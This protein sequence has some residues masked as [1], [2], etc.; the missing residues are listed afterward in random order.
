LLTDHLLL[1][2]QIVAA[3]AAK[4]LTPAVLELG[5]KCPCFIDETCP[6]NIQQVANRV[7]WAKLVNCGQ[8]CISPDYLLVHKSKVDAL[9][10]A[11]RQAL[12]NQLGEN[13]EKSD[14]P[15]LVAADHVKRAKELIE[16]VEERA[17]KNKDVQI[18]CGG[19][20]KCNVKNSYVEPT[21]IFNPPMDSRVMKEELFAPILPIVVVESREQAVKI[22]NDMPGTPLGLYVFTSSDRVFTDMTQMCRSGTAVRNDSLIQFSSSYLPFG[23]L[24]TSGIGNYKGESSF[25]V[26]SQ[27]LPSIYRPS[28]PLADLCNVRCHPFVGWKEWFVL[29]VGSKLPAIPVLKIP[30]RAVYVA[31]VAWSVTRFVPGAEA[32]VQSGRVGLADALL[33]AANLLRD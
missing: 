6:S 31:V 27:M 17:A 30:R 1:L 14:L 9:L 10:P 11:L 18:I 33:H 25:H 4:T 3:A 12:T 29:K 5:G 20:K 23:G 15:K 16:D 7:V 21:F 8:N 26:F 24:G 2:S 28:F 32:L 13:P 19:S 22:I